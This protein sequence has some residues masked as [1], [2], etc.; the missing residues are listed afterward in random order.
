M[1]RG[2]R[3]RRSAACRCGRALLRRQRFAGDG[4]WQ[5]LACRRRWGWCRGTW[6]RPIGNIACGGFKGQ[7]DDE[8]LP[9]THLKIGAKPVPIRQGAHRHIVKARNGIGRFSACHAVAHRLLTRLHRG[10]LRDACLSRINGR[11]CNLRDVTPRTATA[12]TRIARQD[13][14]LVRAQRIIRC[15]AIEP[16]QAVRIN[17]DARCHAA[18]SVTRPRDSKL[19][20][21]IGD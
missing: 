7:W 18:H 11:A 21:G 15:A 6:H 16:R 9:L 10:R 12:H 14:N 2:A 20:I 4:G 8:I 13:Q 19:I 17:T 3:R 1:G 5:S